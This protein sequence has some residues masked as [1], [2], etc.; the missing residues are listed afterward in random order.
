[1]VNVIEYTVK[2]HTDGSKY[3]YLKGEL[4]REDGPAV[5]T[6]NGSKQWYL[7]GELHRENGPAVE[8][9]QGSKHW[10]LKGKRHREDGPAVETSNGSNQWYLKGKKLTEEEHQAKLRPAK[11]YSIEQLEELLGHKIKI[12][13]LT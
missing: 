10:Y 5:E 11:E 7:K 4:H 6:S 1:M 9:F 8:T 12:I 2:V 3:W 13:K